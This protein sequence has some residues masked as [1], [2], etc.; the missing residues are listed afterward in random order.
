MD[1]DFEDMTTDEKCDWLK[2]MLERL[3]V[4]VRDGDDDVLRKVRA[5]IEQLKRA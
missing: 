2:A 4:I 1:L 3:L 5:E